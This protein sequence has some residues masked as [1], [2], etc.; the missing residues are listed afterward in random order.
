MPARP[1]PWTLAVPPEVLAEYAGVMLGAYYAEAEVMLRVQQQTR[2]IFLREYRVDTGSPHVGPPSYVGVA[3]LGAQ[4]VFP[5]DEQPMIANQGRVLETPDQVDALEVP[6]PMQSDLFLRFLAMHEWMRARLGPGASVGL[7]AGQQGPVTAAVLLRGERF[8]EDLHQDPARAHRLLG[9]T[10]EM[11]LRFRDV[12]ARLSGATSLGGGLSDDFAGLLP[13]SLWPEFVLPYWRRLYEALG[14][15]RRSLHSEL[16]RRGHL[17]YLAQLGIVLFDPGMD[18]YLGVRDILEEVEIEF[19]WN[20]FTS[21]DMLQ[22][23]P[24]SIRRLYLGAVAAGA[25]RM[26]AELCR[27]V[28]RENVH[29]YLDVARELGPA[30]G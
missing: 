10:T 8:L 23:T 15:A 14:S 2:A 22:G 30:E 13:P 7:G 26:T 20:I 12:A 18:Q 5:E 4:V 29:A 17:K 3:A 9:V 16:L 27:G 25:P 21:R 19:S 1:V 28:P 24:D 6:D 11:H